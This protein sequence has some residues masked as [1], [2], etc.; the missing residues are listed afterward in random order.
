MVWWKN[1]SDTGIS[2]R[3]KNISTGANSVE[4]PMTA[5]GF[6]QCA[7]ND[8]IQLVVA[9]DS[10]GVIDYLNSSMSIRLVQ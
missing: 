10:S 2:A 7:T 5:T 4:I 9:A 6:I 8:T 3:A 1:G